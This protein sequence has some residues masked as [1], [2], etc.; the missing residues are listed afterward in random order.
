RIRRFPAPRA[1]EG[2]ARPALIYHRHLRALRVRELQFHRDPDRRYWRARA[3]AEIGPGAAGTEG[4]RG[5]HH[6]QLHDRVHR[7][8]AGVIDDAVRFVR[9]RSALQPKVALV[10]GSGLGAFAQEL[11]DSTVIPY[12]DIP[13]WAAS[14]AVGH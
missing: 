3:V 5:W 11:R 12:G 2:R 7:G 1:D 14:T 4:G 8:D 9:T 10:L 6:G 13:G